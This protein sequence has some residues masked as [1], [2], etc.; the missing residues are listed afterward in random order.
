MKPVKTDVTTDHKPESKKNFRNTINNTEKYCSILAVC[1]VLSKNYQSV[2]NILRQ[3]LSLKFFI[4][5]YLIY[6]TLILKATDQFTSTV[7]MRIM[8][9]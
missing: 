1:I 9:R 5:R 3:F 8:Y 7:T 2:N 4:T 6:L